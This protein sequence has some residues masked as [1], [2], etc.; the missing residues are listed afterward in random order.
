MLHPGIFPRRYDIKD[1]GVRH[2]PWVDAL[3]LHLGALRRIVRSADVPEDVEKLVRQWGVLQH[4]AV[5]LLEF[6]S[7]GNRG[8]SVCIVLCMVVLVYADV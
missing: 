3:S 4:I 7:C 2:S 5:I 1:P 8:E 6:Y